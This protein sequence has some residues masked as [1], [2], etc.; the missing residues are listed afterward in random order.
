VQTRAREEAFLYVSNLSVHVTDAEQR[1]HCWRTFKNFFLHPAITFFAAR[2]RH[3]D[4]VLSQA[5]RRRRAARLF[6]RGSRRGQ[7]AQRTT[8]RSQPILSPTHSPALCRRVWKLPYRRRCPHCQ[9]ARRKQEA[10]SRTS[11][12]PNEANT[13]FTNLPEGIRQRAHIY[14]TVIDLQTAPR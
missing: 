10:G 7:S 14:R 9:T 5:R 3:H 8:Q 12:M 4:R 2:P 6:D 11:H 13:F 1:P